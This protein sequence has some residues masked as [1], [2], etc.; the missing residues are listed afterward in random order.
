MIDWAVWLV[1]LAVAAYAGLYLT[2]LLAVVVGTVVAV[3]VVA[4]KGLVA[5]WRRRRAVASAGLSS[6]GLDTYRSRDNAP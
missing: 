6:G 2:V 1:A 4:L 5:A 3:L